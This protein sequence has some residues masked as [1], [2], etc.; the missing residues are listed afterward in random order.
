M[1][2][3]YYSVLRF[4]A[5]ALVGCSD[6]CIIKRQQHLQWLWL[7]CGVCALTKAGIC[8]GQVACGQSSSRSI[9]SWKEEAEV[10]RVRGI[11]NAARCS[12]VSCAEHFE[13][14]DAGSEGESGPR[15]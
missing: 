10:R 12:V 3:F 15:E 13:P 6:C 8:T 4:L 7:Q 1:R 2:V 11:C 9:L 5:R 14:N